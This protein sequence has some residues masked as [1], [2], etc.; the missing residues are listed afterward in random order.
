MILLNTGTADPPVPRGFTLSRGRYFTPEVGLTSDEIVKSALEL[1]AEVITSAAWADATLPDADAAPTAEVGKDVTDWLT[2]HFNSA[3]DEELIAVFIDLQGRVLTI[4]QIGIGGLRY[5]FLPFRHLIRRA[6][7]LN[8]AQVILAHNHLN[9]CPLPSIADLRT[10][11]HIEGILKLLQIDLAAHY[12][13][14]GGRLRAIEP[15]NFD[16]DPA[17]EPG[18]DP[19]ELLSV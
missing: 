18:P 10:T 4:E 14:A 8:S 7:E 19:R 11:R 9:G 15:A 12:I 2:L 5:A 17:P 16:R 13:A 1:V 3:D 6:L